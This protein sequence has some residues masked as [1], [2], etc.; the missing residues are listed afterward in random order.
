MLRRELLKGS[1]ASQGVMH[2]VQDDSSLMLT[3]IGSV[4][5]L[6]LVNF[7]ELLLVNFH[8]N[9]HGQRPLIFNF[10]LSFVFSK[11]S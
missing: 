9:F 6:L 10:Q 11:Y 7:L 2:F 5:E 3:P 4:L 1:Y 8:F